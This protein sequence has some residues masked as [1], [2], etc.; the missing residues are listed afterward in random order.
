MA[1]IIIMEGF[2]FVQAYD[3]ILGPILTSINMGPFM[4]YFIATCR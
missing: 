2:T 1:V 3:A 4:H